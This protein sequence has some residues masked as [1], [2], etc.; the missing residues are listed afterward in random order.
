ME[1]SEGFLHKPEYPISRVYVSDEKRAYTCV[2][3]SDPTKVIHYFLI[4]DAGAHYTPEIVKN[5]K[6]RYRCYNCSQPIENQIFFYVLDYDTMGQFTCSPIPHCC[7]ECA[8]RTI[9][10]IPNNSDLLSNFFLMYGPTISCPPPRVLL[11]LPGGLSL[12]QY[13]ECAA[14][15]VRIEEDSLQVRSFLAPKYYS[16]T[17]FENHQLVQVAKDI[18][19]AMALESKSSIGPQRSREQSTMNVV[20][21]PINNGLSNLASTFVLDPASTREGE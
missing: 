2:P 13:H 17:M 5:C 7:E 20:T 4:H 18:I 11:F 1:C 14:K 19:D 15:N 6:S 3:K 10:D 16:V 21:M 8:L 9:T 12:E